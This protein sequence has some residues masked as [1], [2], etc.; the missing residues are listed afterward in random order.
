ML[1]QTPGSFLWA[2]SLAMRLG[3]EGWSAWGVYLVTGCLQGCLLVICI[4]YELAAWR[5][6]RSGGVDGGV[7]DS[8]RAGEHETQRDGEEAV[9]ERTALL[10]QR[11]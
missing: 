6:K 9:D 5:R 2:A 11:P 1:I 4:M 10:A 7:A 3:R 8:D